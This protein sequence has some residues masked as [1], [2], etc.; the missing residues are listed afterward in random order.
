M[1]LSDT[2][3]TNRKNMIGRFTKVSDH[4]DKYGNIEA[5]Y[6]LFSDNY[7]NFKIGDIIGLDSNTMGI[8]LPYD[9]KYNSLPNNDL[10]ALGAG[11]YLMNKSVF[12]SGAA[13]EKYVSVTNS[14]KRTRDLAKKFVS[15]INNWQIERN[16]TN[17]GFYTFSSTTPNA[18]K[19]SG[20]KLPNFQLYVLDFLNS[21][22][23]DDTA[24]DKFGLKNSETNNKFNYFKTNYE[25][26]HEVTIKEVFSIAK[27]NEIYTDYL[28][29]ETKSTDNFSVNDRVY[30]EDHSVVLKGG[31]F[32][33]EKFLMLNF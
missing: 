32:K 29:F 12:D 16:K 9:Y 24:L 28:I 21:L 18:S 2:N 15:N 22:E 8:I 17:R 19:L 13:F 14:S 30:I 3:V 7:L 33:R 5:D 26:N 10:V 23:D 27:N 20:T 31:D 11:A 6:D 25:P 4:S 1:R